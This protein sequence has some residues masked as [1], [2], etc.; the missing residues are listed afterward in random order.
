MTD[1]CYVVIEAKTTLEEKHAVELV[2][3][4]AKLE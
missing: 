1:A 3:K 2:G 4:G